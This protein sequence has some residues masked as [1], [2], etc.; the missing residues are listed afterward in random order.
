MFHSKK[1]W[2]FS[3]ITLIVFLLGGEV[4]ARLLLNENTP[5]GTPLD[6]HSELGW[7]LPRDEVD[8]EGHPVRRDSQGMRVTSSNSS[9]AQVVYTIGDSSIFG[10]GLED[11]ETL[12]AHIEKEAKKEG[13]SLKSITG[14]V[15]GYSSV[16]S[17]NQLFQYGWDQNPTLLIV[18][19]LW[20]D[21]DIINET[22]LRN[23]SHAPKEEDSWLMRHSALWKWM[24]VQLKIEGD[25]F[26][27]IGWMEEWHN[28][29]GFRR[30]APSRYGAVLD[31]IIR[32]AGSRKIS[33]LLLSP[34]NRPLAAKETLDSG[35]PWDVYF[36][37]M[38]DVAQYR[39]VPIVS[40]CHVAHEQKLMGDKAFID[41]MHP[42]SLLNQAYAKE[43]VHTLQTI[44][45]PQNQ[46]L[47]DLAPKPY[48]K[49]WLDPWPSVYPEPKGRK[50]TLRP[51]NVIHDNSRKHKPG[52][53]PR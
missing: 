37:I 52:P 38:N 24:S 5:K 12:H 40:G 23:E 35:Y 50:Y 3:F 42:T 26:Q 10:H 21:N 27:A 29:S 53:K 44:N 33:V 30:V 46:L 17:L 32:E 39:N 36:D 43:I 28:K 41:R 48:K 7:Q 47:L 20:S 49:I 14:A 19:N 2:L 34:C 15:P 31:R 8:Q 9:A 18:G 16:Q 1:K 4:I 11:H 22:Q 45:W 6:G 13:I 51:D 25:P